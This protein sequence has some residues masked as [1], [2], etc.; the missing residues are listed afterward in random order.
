MMTTQCGTPGYIGMSSFRKQCEFALAPE[1]IAS[2][3]YGPAVD[4]WS[5]GVIIY[6]M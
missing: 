1:I 6:I 3:G 4:F 2:K 5:V